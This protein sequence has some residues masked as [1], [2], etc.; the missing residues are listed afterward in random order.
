[1]TRL[2]AM[3]KLLA[4]LA[5]CCSW[6]FAQSYPAKPITLIIPFPPGGS[7]DIVGRI[8]ADGMAR[9]L[10]QPLVVDNRGGAGGAIGAK[11]IAD[12]APDG[13]TLG[14]ATISTHVV[15]PIVRTDLR[16][17][18]LKDFSFISQIAAVPNVVSIH[19]SVPARNMAEFVAYA[20]QNPGK[21]NFGTPGIGS[22][23]H[24]LGETFKYSAKV[25]MTHVPY[26]GA[27]PALNDAL[28]GQVQVL[29]DNLPSS[30]PHIQAGKLRALAVAS[31]KRVAGLA[32]VPTFAETG[33]PL[34]NDPSWFG[35]IGPAKLPPEIS[36]RLH[37]AL[38]ATLKQPD[39][40]KRLDA[41]ASAPVGN[42]PEAFRKVV[43]EALDNTR[44]VAREANLKF[45]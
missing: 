45:E 6:A 9:E 20:K 37:A 27:G 5:L 13:Y 33:H 39:A 4:L 36:A 40:L 8:A 11:A 1:M 17:D 43:A 28:A 2:L 30:L 42:S 12:A 26:R 24:L 23:G 10:G 44:K 34:V 29:F 22:L 38:V 18:P 16:Y 25:D 31:E 3:T 14:I 32:D 41:A 15:N 21:L 7:T 19:P 35:L